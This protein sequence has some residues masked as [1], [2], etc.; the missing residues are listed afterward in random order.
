MKKITIISIPVTDQQ[1]AKAFYLKAGF[2]LIREADFGTHTWIQL[3]FPDAETSI[4]LVNWFDQMPAGSVRGLVIEVDDIN[5][6]I[7][8]LKAAGIEPGAIDQ[9]PWGQFASVTDPD[10]NVFSLQQVK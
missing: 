4:T 8:T 3:G 1:R 5:Q 2:S 9:T 7:S 6:Q 10:G